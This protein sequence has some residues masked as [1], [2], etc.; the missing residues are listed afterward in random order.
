M[1]VVMTFVLIPGAGGVAWYWHRVVPLLQKAGH[2]ALAVELPGDDPRAGL[3]AYADVVVA[4]MGTRRGTR[5]DVTLVA[6]SMGAFTAAVVCARA[7]KS[8][9]ELVLVNAMIPLPGETAGEWWEHTGWEEAR[10]AAAR[11]GGYPVEFD[12]D[13]YFLHDVPKRIAERLASHGGTRRRSRSASRRPSNGGP[14]FRSTSWQARTIGSFP[15]PFRPGSGANA[16]AGQCTKSRAV[17]SSRSLVRATS[18]SSCSPSFQRVDRRGDGADHPPRERSRP[19]AA[20]RRTQPAGHRGR[21][22]HHEDE[23]RGLD[24]AHDRDPSG[25]CWR[26]DGLC[27]STAAERTARADELHHGPELEQQDRR[28]QGHLGEKKWL[29]L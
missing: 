1:Y 13:T 29:R 5:R 4:A 2:E 18:P 27:G 15:P 20:R 16:S 23:E 11:R 21:E 26:H 9:R 10:A 7:P 12:L 24:V 22:E 17:T 14:T 8:I 6:Q 3:D 28:E 19:S 25:D